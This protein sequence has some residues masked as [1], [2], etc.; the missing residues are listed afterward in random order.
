MGRIVDFDVVDTKLYDAWSCLREMQAQ[1]R[2]AFDPNRR[3]EVNHAGFLAAC[4][5]ARNAFHQRG[6]GPRDKA[7]KDWKSAWVT[8]LTPHDKQLYEYMQHDRDKV[9]HQG[10]SKRIEKKEE[11]KI[12]PHYQDDAYTMSGGTGIPG[13]HQP[14]T[15]K[16]SHYLYEINGVQRDVTAVCAEYLELLK[17]LA[18][19]ARAAKL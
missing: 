6:G 16:K 3:F 8:N 7:I 17:R 5:T 19:D 13:V 9:V 4:A 11:V 1:E 10:Q 2:K 15:F 18:A 14:S 12:G